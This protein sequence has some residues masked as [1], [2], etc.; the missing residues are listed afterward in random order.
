MYKINKLKLQYVHKGFAVG[1]K[2]EK[3]YCVHSAVEWGHFLKCQ[4]NGPI[5]LPGI[6][7]LFR[8]NLF[9]VLYY[10]VY[11]VSMRL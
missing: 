3:A 5:R 9:M 10:G 11:K 4:G 2:R 6:D 8:S 1:I 7:C